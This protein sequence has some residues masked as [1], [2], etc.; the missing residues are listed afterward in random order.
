[1]PQQDDTL[2]Q[3]EYIN[4]GEG[5]QVG[6]PNAPQAP[7][8]QMWDIAKQ[9]N[10][11]FN[12]TPQQLGWDDTTAQKLSA[13]GITTLPGWFN[14]DTIYSDAFHLGSHNPIDNYIDLYNTPV[15]QAVSQ[16][17]ASKRTAQ[18]LANWGA[19]ADDPNYK[20]AYLRNAFGE[21]NN[22]KDN[23]WDRNQ[24]WVMGLGGIASV[25]GLGVLGEA[26]LLG[27]GVGAEAGVGAGGLSA[28]DASAMLGESGLGYGVGGA[29]GLGG[30][31]TVEGSGL[32]GAGTFGGASELG[33]TSG[34]MP[35]EVAGASAGAGTSIGDI[36]SQAEDK[37]ANLDWGKLASDPKLLGSLLSGMG[38]SGVTGTQPTNI[39]GGSTSAPQ[40]SQITP[41]TPMGVG[42]PI[43]PATMPTGTM[44]N[45]F[46][47]KNEKP[48]YLKY[49]STLF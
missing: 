44:M 31:G 15:D 36:L 25:A 8:T 2:N 20:E 10:T 34:L 16:W 47:N 14:K 49:F 3:P 43:A 45:A 1:M 18:N 38:L 42:A 39:M 5:A 40:T 9:Q 41:A 33:G 13:A 7:M 12:Y 48:D 32:Y 24:G 28:A 27:A 21:L 11:G 37:L 23:W 46:G 6:A 30:I 35:G 17:D 26:G 19:T 22:A 4:Q 29:S